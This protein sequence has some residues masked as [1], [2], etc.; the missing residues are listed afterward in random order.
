MDPARPTRDDWPEII[1]ALETRTKEIRELRRRIGE[2]GSERSS[3]T[4]RRADH[5]RR[6]L[7]DIALFLRGE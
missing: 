6:I 1:H 2:Q 5:A 7:D 3:E 4:A